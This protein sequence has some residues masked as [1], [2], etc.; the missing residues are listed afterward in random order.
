MEVTMD[1]PKGLKPISES[2]KRGCAVC[3]GNDPKTCTRCYGKTRLCDWF[4]TDNGITHL[5][6]I[7]LD[8]LRDSGQLAD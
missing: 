6:Q 3:D 7:V 2:K 1:K 4:Y 5:T 8:G